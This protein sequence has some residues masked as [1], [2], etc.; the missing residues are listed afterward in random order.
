MFA[1]GSGKLLSLSEA[2]Y[3]KQRQQLFYLQL[4][5]TYPKAQ[6]S[7][8][9]FSPAETASESSA[10]A[11]WHDSDRLECTGFFL[12]C[13]LQQSLVTK[14]NILFYRNNKN[15]QFQ[16]L[17]FISLSLM[18][19]KYFNFSTPWLCIIFQLHLL[20]IPIKSLMLLLA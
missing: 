3:N 4:Y 10:A 1:D 13:V 2:R 12:K 7:D 15:D 8:L 5:L 14:E 16:H 9:A 20:K 19:L 17:L 18:Y 11:P 6:E